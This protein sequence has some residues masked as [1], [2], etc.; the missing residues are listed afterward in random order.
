MRGGKNPKTKSGERSQQL[1]SMEVRRSI[2]GLSSSSYQ[3]NLFEKRKLRLS[4]LYMHAIS[5]MDCGLILT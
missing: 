1:P 5:Y 3:F 2:E 4:K